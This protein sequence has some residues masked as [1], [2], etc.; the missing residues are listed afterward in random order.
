MKQIQEK[1]F[2]LQKEKSKICCASIKFIIR[3][4]SQ[5]LQMLE[6][7]DSTVILTQVDRLKKIKLFL[8]ITQITILKASD[9][10]K[11]T[12]GNENKLFEM[13]LFLFTIY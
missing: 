4:M 8:K 10:C 2:L 3:M 13:Y 12:T 9:E 1:L 11:D 5:I 6:N 7:V